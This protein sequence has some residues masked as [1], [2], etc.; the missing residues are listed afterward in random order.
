MTDKQIELRLRER[1]MTLA[2]QAAVLVVKDQPSANLAGEL[3]AD[4]KDMVRTI[5]A[6]WKDAKADAKAAHARLCAMEAEWLGMVEPQ[7]LTLSRK[8]A[9]WI[10]E[11]KARVE[12]E[13]EEREKAEW[14]ARRAKEA[15]VR[16]V[17]EAVNFED[18][19]PAVAQIA[20]VESQVMPAKPQDPRAEG[21]YFRDNWRW[22]C[23]D[24]DLVPRRFLTLDEKQIGE[25]VRLNKGETRIPGIEIFNEPSPVAK[26][27]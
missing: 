6:Y 18:A 12:K 15:A 21:V 1:T 13:R 8:L 17:S 7:M 9:A 11:E 16:A 24:F 3:I 23:V 26:R 5:K 27:S 4:M 10:Q 22:R 14:E 25:E 2:Q 19:A 20:E